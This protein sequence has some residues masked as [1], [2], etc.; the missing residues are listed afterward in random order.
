MRT[1]SERLAAFSR[2]MRPKWSWYRNSSPAKNQ[3]KAE[4]KSDLP[5]GTVTEKHSSRAPKKRFL[6]IRWGKNKTTAMYYSIELILNSKV[7]K[8]MQH[9]IGNVRYF[10]TAYCEA[11]NKIILNLGISRNICL[12]CS[13]SFKMKV[14]KST[15]H[16]I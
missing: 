3:M 5:D 7:L 13:S 1:R 11:N 6:K 8:S 14:L 16:E 15:Q 4:I 12:R 10:Y 9:C 2:Q